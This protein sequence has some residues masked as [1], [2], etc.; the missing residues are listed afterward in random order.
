[1]ERI[2]GSS[3][4]HAG[5]RRV[6]SSDRARRTCG[7]T[8]RQ[9]VCRSRGERG[10]QQGGEREGAPATRGGSC[11]CQAWDGRSSRQLRAEVYD[12]AGQG[13]ADGQRRCSTLYGRPESERLRWPM[14]IPHFSR[15]AVGHTRCSDLTASA[16][17]QPV[18]QCLVGPTITDTAARLAGP[19]CAQRDQ[20]NTSRPSRGHVYKVRSLQGGRSRRDQTPA[21]DESTR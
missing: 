15:A 18:V 11:R 2:R 16:S 1:V 17:G 4:H 3:R 21:G 12:V 9:Q 7:A 14:V 20:T 5:R 6:S 13:M 19:S 8:A 10:G